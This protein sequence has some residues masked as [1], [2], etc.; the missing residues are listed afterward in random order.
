MN[1][2]QGETHFVGSDWDS[3][4]G[5]RRFS[6]QAM[7][8]TFEVFI[9]HEDGRYARQAAQAAFD[10]LA[11]LAQQLSRYIENSDIS[12]INNLVVGRSLRIGLDT[13]ECLQIS[14]RI[15]DQTNGAFDITVGS[16]M[17]CW[18]NS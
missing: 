4:A 1:Q 3:I 11:P 15:F 17:R 5:L 6:H 2:P 9:I 10:R 8:T 18:L 12:R 13:F 14:R 7:A 16:L